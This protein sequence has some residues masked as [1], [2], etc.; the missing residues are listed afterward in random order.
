[1]T[2]TRNLLIIVALMLVHGRGQRVLG[3]SALMPQC[4]SGKVH[5]VEG[6]LYFR[7]QAPAID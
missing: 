6:H 5:G 1:M 7:L 2:G 3:K 4:N